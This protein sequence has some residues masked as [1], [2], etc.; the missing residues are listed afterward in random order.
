MKKTRIVNCL[1]LDKPLQ[2]ALLSS[3]SEHSDPGFM[4]VNSTLPE[5]PVQAAVRACKEHTGILI[6]KHDWVQFHRERQCHH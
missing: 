5:S 3:L 4:N 1:L 2:V 6:P